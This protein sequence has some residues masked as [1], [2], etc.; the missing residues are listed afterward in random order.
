MAIFPS[1]KKKVQ[2][3]WGYCNHMVNYAVSELPLV[4]I[5]LPANIRETT[6]V[7]SQLRFVKEQF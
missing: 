2:F 6:V 7:Q 3:F 4:D 1:S 5:T